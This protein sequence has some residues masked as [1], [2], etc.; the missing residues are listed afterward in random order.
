MHGLLV[1]RFTF[2]FSSVSTFPAVSAQQ[3]PADLRRA[4]PSAGELAAFLFWTSHCPACG[5]TPGRLF[6]SGD[7]SWGVS[8]ILEG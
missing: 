4:E 3:E 5:N 2:W 6:P 7:R 1:P 8:A